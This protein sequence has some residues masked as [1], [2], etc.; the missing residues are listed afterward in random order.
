MKYISTFLL[1]CVSI[2]SYGQTSPNDYNFSTNTNASLYN[3][4]NAD[5]LIGGGQDNITDD[6]RILPFTFAFLGFFHK[7][8][9]VT[10]NGVVYLSPLGG[11]NNYYQIAA[12][13]ANGNNDYKWNGTGM[14]TSKDGA[15]VCK[16]FG[17]EPYRQFVISFEKMSL[18]KR[19]G[20]DDATFQVALHESSGQVQFI[21]GN[22]NV[23][24]TL[25]GFLDPRIS[26]TN[27]N[28]HKIV[29]ISNHTAYYSTSFPW[30][31]TMNPGI[32]S[33]LHSP[34]A[35]N[36]RT[37]LFTPPPIANF[38]DTVL[39][40]DTVVSGVAQTTIPEYQ[41]NYYYYYQFAKSPSGPFSPPTVLST[42]IFQGMPD[43]TLHYRIYKS[44]GGAVST[45]YAS[46]SITFGS[47]RKF[48]SQNSGLWIDN[49]AWG[50]LVGHYPL[51]GDTVVISQGDTI[52]LSAFGSA[53]ALD[54]DVKG[55]LD[56]GNVLYNP[57][58][59]KNLHV[60]TTG[61]V[62]VHNGSTVSNPNST[63]G[64]TLIV[65]GNMTGA[66][67]VDMRY[68]NCTLQLKNAEEVVT[69]VISVN[70]EQGNNNTPL[71]NT[72]ILS[73][74]NTVQLLT[75]L[76]INK[77]IK[78]EYGSITTNNNLSINKNAT[79]GTQSAPSNLK[80]YRY[81]RAPLFSGNVNFAVGSLP[82]LYYMSNPIYYD[83][84][85]SFSVPPF[86][87]G[88]EVPTNDSIERL[89]VYSNAGVDFNQ[90]IT[91]TNTMEW[92]NGH[93]NMVNGDDFILSG[94]NF[95]YTSGGIKTNG[96]V[97][98]FQYQ[99]PYTGLM[100]TPGNSN[101]YPIVSDNKKRFAFLQGALSA[102]GLYSVKHTDIAGT[103]T[104]ATS[105]TEN[106][107]TF[108]K[109]SNAY[110]EV[111]SPTGN[112]FANNA[113]HFRAGDM[114]S[115]T[116]HQLT[117]VCYASGAGAGTHLATTGGK[118]A[119]I[120]SRTGLNSANI[121]SNKFYIAITDATP[122]SVGLLSFT[123]K[124]E[125]ESN[126]LK[127]E[128]ATKHSLTEIELQRSSNGKIFERLALAD[129]NDNQ[130]AYSYRDRNP[131][132]GN[133]F[134]RLKIR[135]KDTRQTY[136]HTVMLNSSHSIQ[137]IHCFPN[138]AMQTLY[139]SATNKPVER[140]AIYNLSGKAEM[141]GNL[142]VR[143]GVNSIDIHRLTEGVYLLQ[144]YSKTE[145]VYTAKFIKE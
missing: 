52:T 108:S 142:D 129:I 35:A 144:L 44:N 39:V 37:Y 80:I 13:S 72:L 98:Y 122:L 95:Y 33:G 1:F 73:T 68:N 110:W 109:R 36:C 112:E 90:A 31:Y 21:Y 113:F 82:Q 141:K 61:V 59:V 119:P 123:G 97:K 29:N 139:I 88:N 10:A 67:K 64:G 114:D 94:T 12:L 23:S 128:L 62:L 126:L 118:V 101:V 93:V 76:T 53:S 48:T 15:V 107:N 91:I 78:G 45:N 133:N 57:V 41:P 127:W 83:P 103:T 50:T 135:E 96:W 145:C 55:V 137:D 106:G 51:W 46:G 89:Y 117:A 125:S 130:T 14:G 143:N 124:S 6:A 71:L 86:T 87:A 43:S 20:N 92:E 25:S 16:T 63:T 19:M 104:F 32:I 3:M 40:V 4:S 60:D 54:L 7:T 102:D 24:D 79:V 30:A 65:A 105:F 131:F 2:N 116:D 18:S 99:Y 132:D 42:N 56:Y 70:F 17:T 120:I 58:T 8:F 38:M 84:L 26:K 34:V 75:P 134:Y 85:A 66:G 49:S 74:A 27:V 100:N 138:P 81:S 5:T 69:H 22:V 111:S 28:Q 115:I 140:F 136:S 121:G 77:E 47:A 11:S 9:S